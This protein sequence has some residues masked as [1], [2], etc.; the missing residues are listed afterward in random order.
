MNLDLQITDWLSL[1]LRWAHIIAGIGWIG[2]S[3]LLH[4]R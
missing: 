3:F 2:A 4:G 1:T